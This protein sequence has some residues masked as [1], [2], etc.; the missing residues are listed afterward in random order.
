[1]K[2]HRYCS[3]SCYDAAHPNFSLASVVPPV[4]ERPAGE[5][6]LCAACAAQFTPAPVT[7]YRDTTRCVYCQ[8]RSER[9]YVDDRPA[10]SRA[11]PDR[12]PKRLSSKHDA[13]PIDLDAA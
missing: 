8:C 3:A 12:T 7:E 11:L 13:R 10:L 2:A 6:S 5:K 1:V 9:P 4:V